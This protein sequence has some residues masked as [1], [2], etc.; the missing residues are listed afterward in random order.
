MKEKAAAYLKKTII[1]TLAALLLT[2]SAGPSFAANGDVEYLKHEPV[3]G[4]NDIW[5][6]LLDTKNVAY[7][8]EFPYA[9]SFFRNPSNQFSLKFAQ[10]SLGLALSAFRS[11]SGL[12]DYQY[13]KYLEGAGFTNLF[14]FGYDKETTED[15][16]SGVIGMKQIDDFTVIAAVTCG[17]GYGK[18]WAGN[19]K[20]GSGVRHEGFE[21]AADM[22][23]D[24]ISQ[25]I[26]DNN[27]EGEKKLWLT[28]IS[29]A[30]AIGNITA[31]DSIES[32][33]YEDV[34]AYLF[35]VP[36]TTKEPIAYSGI[37]NICGQYDP[38]AQTPFQSWGYERYGIDLYTPAQ[39]SDARYPAYARKAKKVAK[40][41]ADSFRNNPEV[42]YQLR[43]IMEGLNDIFETSDDYAE[44]FEPILLAAM[45][46][47]TEK[48]WLD[49]LREALSK[50]KSKDAQER[51]KL[52][53]YADYLSYMVGQHTRANQRQVADGSW[54]PDEGIDA[55]LMIEHRPSTYIKWLFSQD[56]P[57]RLF[58]CGTDSRRIT[59]IGNVSVEVYRDGKGISG[60]NEKGEVYE[61]GGDDDRPGTG[62]KG[63]FLMRN[64]SQTVLSLPADTEY[65]VSM[66]ATADGSL[67]MFDILVSP[68]RLES[69]PG[70]MYTGVLHP[71]TYTFKVNAGESPDEPEEQGAAEEED[72]S[73]FREAEFRYLPV[74]V[75]SN[76]LD[77]TRDTFFSMSG[78]FLLLIRVL[79][80]LA[81]LIVIC[82]V[83]NI[84]HRIKRKRGHAPYSD[85][86]VIVPHLI[87]IVIFAAMTQYAS[88]YMF[89]V[90]AIRAQLAA[91]TMFFTF[92][93]ALR[94][95]IRSRVPIHF[96]I[97]GFLLIAVHLTGVYYNRLPIDSFS[98]LNMVLFFVMV[99]LFC[100]LAIHMFK[101]AKEPEKDAPHS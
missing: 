37:Y 75:M 68:A 31:A 58:A 64:G 76:E 26:R 99:A 38:V 85:W 19:F 7:G 41:M 36:R 71:G 14:A 78:A 18:E 100:A 51:Y 61:P 69:Q 8:W 10:G 33:E 21:S 40:K 27:I 50:V 32:G 9:D 30:G 72:H 74:I 87:C 65:D 84:I 1:I 45:R 43:L 101:H 88:F 42:N 16:L 20:V 97:A 96:L 34:Y 77:A 94:G 53:E 91:V 80:L 89:T 95:A 67:T 49:T 86:F 4:V 59:L 54:D 60:I 73:H 17:Q 44:R 5:Y 29:R 25:Y 23:K 24:Y 66:I 92:L 70:K 28:G 46:D 81:V 62:K 3:Y 11:N 52:T 12:L 56:D 57:A 47:R 2:C 6:M 15:S 90:G 82:L 13:E 55:N 83:I 98:I 48:A 22:L 39:E 35:G 93:L 79:Q 63:T